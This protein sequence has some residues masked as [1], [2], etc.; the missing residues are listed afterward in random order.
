[1]T[2]QFAIERGVEAVFQLEDTEL[3][4]QVLPD[5]DE[6]GRTM[7]VEAAEGGAGVLR[8][9]QAEPGALARAARE[10]LR[11]I[12]VDPDTG[13]DRDEACVRGCYRCLLSYSNQTVHESI[14]RRLIVDRLLDL[15]GAQ[16]QPLDTSAAIL[17]EGDDDSLIAA[18]LSDRARS[19]LRLLSIRKLR[20]PDAVAAGVDGYDAQVDMVYRTGGLDT[21]VVVEDAAAGHRPDPT[22][23]AFAGWNVIHIGPDEDLE[24]IVSAN[25][26]V[27][28]QEAR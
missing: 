13:Q 23:L 26:A 14:D 27:F 8:R 9:L 21:V 4:S 25:P 20:R 24:T 19:L 5:V 6:H 22:A 12:H 11:I 7:F 3:T 2:L 17:A 1:M 16:V 10:A 15:A 28:G 18:A